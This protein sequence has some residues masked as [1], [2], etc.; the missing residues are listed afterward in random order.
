MFEAVSDQTA[1]R[2][3]VETALGRR[4]RHD[5]VLP[6]TGGPAGNALL[7]A[8]LGLVLLVLFL[9][10]G[11]TLVDVRGLI[12]WHVALGAL[13][14]PPVLAKTAT[15]GWRMVRYYAGHAGY[16]VAGPPPL[17]LRMLG[18]L[19]VLTSLALLGS[20]VA[21]VLLGQDA[22]RQPVVSALGVRVDWVGV[23]KGVFIVWFAVMTAHVLA[24]ALP[25][26]RLAMRR[27]HRD[28]VPG[29]TH[30][31]TALVLS[32]VLAGTA[33]V[34]LVGLEGSW[35]DGRFG[36]DDQEHVTTSQTH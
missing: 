15:T 30:R 24:R 25:A 6:R 29:T 36:D 21:L 34:W 3:V 26:L 31:T 10:E 14:V 22:S 5:P 16:R 23:H 28:R 4:E 8:W 2:D 11:L 7:T 32:L 1:V 19:V 13:L 18:P 27:R 12:S 17:V 9:A 33:A 35:R 20:G